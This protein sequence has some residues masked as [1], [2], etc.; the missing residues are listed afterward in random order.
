MIVIRPLPVKDLNSR[1][2]DSIIELDGPIQPF[3]QS[4]VSH[5]DVKV[6]RF[7]SSC[8]PPLSDLIGSNK[9]DMF[10]IHG[11]ESRVPPRHENIQDRHTVKVICVIASL[12][13]NSPP[14]WVLVTCWICF[15]S[16]SQVNY[17]QLPLRNNTLCTTCNQCNEQLALDVRFQGD[18]ILMNR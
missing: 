15:L 6:G 14:L 16:L 11:E 1:L 8:E 17:V 3:D 9:P 10:L 4:A 2:L 13:Y 7:A 12:S 5:A 18:C